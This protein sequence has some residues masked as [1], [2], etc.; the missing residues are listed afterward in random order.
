MCD[1]FESTSTKMQNDQV[2]HSCSS[3]QGEQQNLETV[4]VSSS[5]VKHGIFEHRKIHARHGETQVEIGMPLSKLPLVRR[6]CPVENWSM[7]LVWTVERLV[8]SS[9]IQ[10]S[11]SSI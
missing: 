7:S 6:D 10:F 11:C 8:R 3:L 5:I 1:S 4:M 2:F 9:I